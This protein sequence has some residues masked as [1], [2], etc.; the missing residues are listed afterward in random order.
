MTPEERVKQE[1]EAATEEVALL[2]AD[3]RARSQQE[4]D[5]LIA[6]ASRMAGRVEAF[7]VVSKFLTVSS[8]IQLKKI[9]ESKIYR[10]IPNVET[11]EKF[12]NTIGLSSKTVDENI[13]NLD[14]LGSEFLLT[15]QHFGLGYR[16]LRQLKKA[17]SSGDLVIEADAVVVDGETIP[18]NNK[19]E[20]KEAL[21]NL[22]A[23]QNRRLKEKD[24]ELK[25]K[26]ELL[27]IKTESLKTVI[28]QKEAI[29]KSK[30]GVNAA[31]SETIN[32]LSDELKKA[33]TTVS[34]DDGT[35]LESDPTYQ[36]LL[37][38]QH[39][40]DILITKF[41]VASKRDDLSEFHQNIFGGLFMHFFK[42]LDDIRQTLT[43]KDEAHFFDNFYLTEADKLMAENMMTPSR[44]MHEKSD[45]Q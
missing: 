35:H 17:T 1:L 43:D 24:E 31:Q 38:L 45:E 28:A 41:Q 42:R 7:G 11:W 5:A 21:E 14:T 9:K 23:E 33:K 40:A 15:C 8:L 25:Q 6:E 10:E 12:C 3:A 27:H 30:D 22:V 20:L 13:R 29:I 44:Y 36:A 32:R 34:F 37:K 2:E 26:D 16:E 39:E 4:R 19:D 18:L